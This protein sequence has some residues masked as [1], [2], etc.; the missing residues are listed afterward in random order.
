MNSIYFKNFLISAVLVIFCFLIV[1]TAFVVLG[2]GFLISDKRETM[3][4]NARE[5][6]LVAQ[7]LS[8]EEDA[9]SSWEL[10]MYLTSVAHIT[11]NH[12]FLTDAEGTVI[13]CSDREMICAHMGRQIGSQSLILLR[14]NGE[15][16]TLTDLGGFYEDTHYVIAEPI[17]LMGSGELVGYVFVGYNSGAIMDAWHTFLLV[18]AATSA[19]VLLVAVLMAYVAS[20]RQAKPIKQ[21]VSAAHSFARGDFSARIEDDGREDEIGDLTRSFNTMAEALEQAERRRQEFISNVSHELKTP[22]TAISGF[23]DGILDGTIPPESQKQYLTTISSETKRLARLVRRMLDVAQIQA[24]TPAALHKTVFDV[25]ELLLRTL[26]NFEQKVNGKGLD[27]DVQVPEERMMVRADED[28]INQVIYNLLDNA[29]KF[30]EAGTAIGI[31]LWKQG[32]KAYVAVRNHGETIPENELALIFDRF[33]KT[34][35]SRSQDREGVG[36]GLYIVRSIINNHDQDIFVTSKD[37]VTEFVF[38]LDMA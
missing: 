32:G 29:I 2:R 9:L 3:S 30:A 19:A 21:M 8:Q 1:G 16:N 36:L 18:F 33:H 14:T 4:A 25:S 37:G 13:S 11:G 17:T 34:D 5:L 35:R 10:R 6:A 12:I 27:V 22:M 20:R 26:L 24:S 7:T 15:L 23:A 38:T 31:S 28:A